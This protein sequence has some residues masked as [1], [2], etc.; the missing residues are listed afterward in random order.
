[1]SMQPSTRES[2]SLLLR[3]L[4]LPTFVERF[5]E[6]AD[7]AAKEGW[8]FECYLH[9]LCAAEISERRQRRIGRHLKHSGLPR[10]KT[11]ATLKQERLP[12]PV[13]VGQ[14]KPIPRGVAG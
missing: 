13:P 2:L 1:M 11:L 4:K 5:A 9:E 14:T 12:A 6:V 8:G 10:D 3:E 7:R